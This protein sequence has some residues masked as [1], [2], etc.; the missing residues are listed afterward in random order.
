[1]NKLYVKNVNKNKNKITVEY[2]IKGEWVKY[3]NTKEKF[4]IEYSRNIEDVPNSICVL[5]FIANVLPILWVTNATI[6][7]EEL[8]KNFYECL[9]NVKRGYINIFPQIQFGGNV[10]VKKLCDNMYENSEN[11]ALFF[12]GGLDSFSTLIGH[13]SENPEIITIWGSDIELNDLDGW[14]NVTRHIEKVTNTF[15]IKNNLIKTNFRTF[16]NEPNLSC[17]IEKKVNDGWWHAFQ[18]G[19]GIIAQA[20]PIA[21]LDKLSKVYI[22]SS[23]SEKNKAITCASDPSIDN[24]VKFASCS[25]CHDQYNLT[26]MQKTKKIVEYANNTGIYSQLR[27]C[28]ISRG[29]KNCCH[30]EKCY[31]TIYELIACGED[32]NKYGL[33]F[34]DKVNKEAKEYI[35]YKHFIDTP[36]VPLWKE[37]KEEFLN[38]KSIFAKSKYKWI[39]KIRPEK[40]NKNLMKKFFA[41]ARKI[42]RK[43]IK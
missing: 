21:Y 29:G 39:Y 36:A 9:K 27:V 42:K 18:H 4:F 17:M 40:D 16:I 11:V 22:A 19:I 14:N 32:P 10:N 38:Q 1:M 30:C 31:R 23:Y 41:I 35:M 24:Y 34:N 20:A 5:P 12:S 2:E 28:W 43:L 3:F 8:D 37:I 25:V 15:N 7:V 13:I 33:F 6:F 26:R